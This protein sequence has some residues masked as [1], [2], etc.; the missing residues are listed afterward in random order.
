MEAWHGG[1]MFRWSSGHLHKQRGSV[2]SRVGDFWIRGRELT[3]D[4]AGNT[5]SQTWQRC[6]CDSVDRGGG[7]DIYGRGTHNCGLYGGVS[8]NSAGN[9]D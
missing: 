6:S 9:R 8:Q 7:F 3:F 1:G 2:G 5:T 4:S